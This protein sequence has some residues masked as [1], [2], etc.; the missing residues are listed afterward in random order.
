MGLAAAAAMLVGAFGPWAKAIG[1]LN[2][3]ISGTDG[4]N[5]GWIVA[6]VAVAGAAS[7]I[8]YAHGPRIAALGAA[9]AGAAGGAVTYYDR[10]NI[11]DAS[12][13]STTDLAVLQVGWGLN[14]AM[15]A[16]VV[17]AVVGLVALLGNQD[18]PGMR[19]PG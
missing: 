13:A 15:G 2:V 6:G 18:A 16:S 19:Q 17:L 1:L 11:T 8:A 5:D 14:L 7:L 4:S 12:D 10:N 9:L 3:S